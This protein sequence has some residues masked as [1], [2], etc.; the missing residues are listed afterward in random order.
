MKT[1]CLFDID[2]TL[3]NSGGAGQQAMESALAEVFSLHGPYE[4][5]PAAG[6]TDKAITTDLFAW[7]GLEVDEAGWDRFLEAYLRHLPA[8][9]AARDGCIL[10]GIESLLPEL[11]RR[12]HVALGL[13]TGNLEVGARV[14]LRH[15]ALD[16]HF[17]FG[18]YGD[19]HHD[20]DEV[21]R[22]AY[23]AACVYLSVPPDTDRVWVIG[24]TPADVKCARA[25][26]AKC[27]AVATG[28]YSSAELEP[29]RPDAL[30]ES[31]GDVDQVL[32]LLAG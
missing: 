8:A 2:G 1:V 27:L 3:L 10:P 16:R 28:I 6:R 24:D 30:L 25:I 9:L 19:H 29:S 14:K 4:D 18:G 20:R 21:A 12:Q 7:H 5:I 17:H 11:G 32:A 31:L 13:L 23:D 26:G 22:A 15:Y